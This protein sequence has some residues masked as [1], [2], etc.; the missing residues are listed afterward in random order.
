SLMYWGLQFPPDVRRQLTAARALQTKE[1]GAMPEPAVFARRASAFCHLCGQRLTGR[2]YR[3]SVGLVFCEACSAARPRCQRCAAPLDAA[4]LAPA[5]SAVS[6]E[7]RLCRRCL[8]TSP[9]CAACRRQIAGSWY[10]FEELVPPPALRRF[11][12]QCVKTRPRCDL[13]RV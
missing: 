6:D 5:V 11:C 3:H 2:Y 9:R 8:R 12:E 4:L 13:C 1:E 7:P 10:T